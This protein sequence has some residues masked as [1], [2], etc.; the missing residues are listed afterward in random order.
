MGAIATVYTIIGFNTR[1]R[2]FAIFYLSIAAMGIIGMLFSGTRG[3]LVVP[4]AGLALYCL[5]C[6]SIRTFAITIITGLCIFAFLAFTDIGNGNSFIRRARTAFRPTADAS[7][8]V[9]IQNRKEMALY[10]K[11]Y[12]FGIGIANSIPKLWLKQ[13]LTYEEGTLPPDSYFVSIWIQTGIVGL[14]LNITIYLVTL[15]GC[16]YIVMF[17]VKDRYLRHQLAAFTCTVFGILLSGYTGYAPGMPPTNFI[18]VAMIA[19]V[20]NGAYIDK[21]ITQQKLT[22]NKQ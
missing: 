3:A 17:K 4:F 12:P 10:L 15:L 1:N 14:V 19:F 9:R 7:F 8:N 20:M 22:I 21:Q 13:D 16:C 6:K 5:I 11:D 18:I 2:K